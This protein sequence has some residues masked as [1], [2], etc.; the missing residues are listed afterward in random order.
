MSRG[1][2]TFRVDPTVRCRVEA[3]AVHGRRGAAGRRCIV[4]HA[5]TAL[6]APVRVAGGSW[7]TDGGVPVYIGYPPPSG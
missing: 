2:E 6:A 3:T 7:R 1:G 4:H 5:D